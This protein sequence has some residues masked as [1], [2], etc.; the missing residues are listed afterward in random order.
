M[1]TLIGGILLA[2]GVMLYVLEPVFSGRAAPRYGGDDDYDEGVAR[3]R[4][5]LTALRDLEYDRITGKLDAADYKLL[6]GELARD[7][8]HRLDSDLVIRGEGD[9]ADASTIRDRASLRLEAEIAELRAALRQGLQCA[10][11]ERL[12]RSGSHYCGRC[13]RALTRPDEEK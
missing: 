5:A 2:A 6:K 13:G 12:N 1:T 4:V 11:C 9:R 8:L 10:A 7:A 3:R